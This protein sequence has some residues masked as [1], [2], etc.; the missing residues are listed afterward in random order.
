MVSRYEYRPD[1]GA[2]LLRGLSNPVER[3]LH[4]RSGS[5][6]IQL[7]CHTPQSQRHQDWWAAWLHVCVEVAQTV[8]L[9]PVCTAGGLLLLL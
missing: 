3:V 7:Y 6:P 8:V 1:K 9:A 2:D 4:G 5:K